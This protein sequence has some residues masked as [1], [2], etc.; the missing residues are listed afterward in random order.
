MNAKALNHNLRL[1]TETELAGLL[2][3]RLCL[4]LQGFFVGEPLTVEGFP[5]AWVAFMGC[6]LPTGE[7]VGYAMER[8][9]FQVA[10]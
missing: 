8:M 6:N 7:A 2:D 5:F 10:S 1:P 3:I 4:A 9:G